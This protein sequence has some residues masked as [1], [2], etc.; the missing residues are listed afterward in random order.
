VNLDPRRRREQPAGA[1]IDAARPAAA[2]PAAGDA[3]GGGTVGEGASTVAGLAAVVVAI[4]CFSIST[5]LIKW[6]GETGSVVAFWR[7]IGA[8]VAWWIVLGA[9]RVRSHR[10]YPSAATWRAVLLP[11]L[12]FGA[13]I[14]T[15]FTAITRTSI[16]HAEFIGTLSPLVLLPAGAVLFG[17]H[18]NWGAL[19]WGA[20]SVVGVAFVLFFGPDTGVAGLSGDLLMIVVVALWTSYLL[21]SKRARASG[22]DTVD[23]MACLM[24]LGLLTA[25]PIAL[26]IAGQDV[27]GLSA[28][29][30]L[31]VLLLV[32]LTGMLA[33][34]C[35]IFAQRLVP[36][37]TIG[38]MQTSQP[39]LAVM[40]A[41]VILGETVLPLQVAGMAMVVLGLALFTWVSQ[42]PARRTRA[43]AGDA[44]TRPTGDRP[45]R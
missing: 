11:A 13:N 8:V 44:A 29:G 12:F 7:M 28:R 23:F 24:P 6:S 15:L 37:A 33:H 41:F 27:L 22:V 35:I 5:P 26:L 25:G 40:W 36:V 30:W 32:V 42:A 31:V 45:G 16:A 9:L 17:E 2:V 3:A 21:T 20:L 1:G 4:T 14:A 43:A 38:V 19:R 18:P 39:A 10:P 34:G